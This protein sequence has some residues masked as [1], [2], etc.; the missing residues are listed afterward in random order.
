M[1]SKTTLTSLPHWPAA[2]TEDAAAAYLSLSR[3]EFRRSV[4]RGDLPLPRRFGRQRRWSRQALDAALGDG[5]AP[6]PVRAADAVAPGGLRD[7]IADAI[8]ALE[9]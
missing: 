8:A 3:A 5:A 9:V 1:P 4:A 6:P 2:L 7:P